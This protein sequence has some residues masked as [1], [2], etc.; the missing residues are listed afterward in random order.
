MSKCPCEF[1]N[2][3]KYTVQEYL[4]HIDQVIEQEKCNE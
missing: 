1:C 3:K 2:A 4:K